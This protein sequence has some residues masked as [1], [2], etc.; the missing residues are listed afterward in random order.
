MPFYKKKVSA[1]SLIILVRQIQPKSILYAPRGWV[2][3][4]TYRS[5]PGKPSTVWLWWSAHIIEVGLPRPVSLWIS[6]M[7]CS[8]WQSAS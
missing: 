3:H 7:P 8:F 2:K 1:T 6:C 4:V 5:R